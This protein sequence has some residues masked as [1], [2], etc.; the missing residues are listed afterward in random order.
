[1]HME[2][3]NIHA[4]YVIAEHRVGCFGNFQV[5]SVKKDQPFVNM[6]WISLTERIIYKS[7]DFAFHQTPTRGTLLKFIL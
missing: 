2:I 7:S 1:M 3:W 4:Y 5:E 6:I